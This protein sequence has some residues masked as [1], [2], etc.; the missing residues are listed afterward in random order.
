MK[1]IQ[2]IK[3]VTLLTILL[4]VGGISAKAQ[5]LDDYSSLPPFVGNAVTP[6]ILLLVDN[7]G[8]M[9][10]C[11]YPNSSANDCRS[12]SG[13]NLSDEYSAATD[14]IG[15]FDYNQCYNYASS[16]FSSVGAKPC[17][18]AWDGNFLNWVT[19]RRIDIVKWVMTGG[20]C[21]SVRSSP[22]S[23]STLRGQSSF[24]SAACCKRIYKKFNLSGLAPSSY[25][26]TRCIRVENGNFYV[27]SNSSC[28]S[29]GGTSHFIRVEVGTSTTGVIQD[30]G[31][32][33]RF[34][35]M[36]FDDDVSV[37]NG[38]EIKSDI[39]ANVVSMVNGIEGMKATSWT[40][41]AES[42]YEA[43]RYFAQIPPA[44]ESNDFKV[45]V[46]ND[47]Y[48][49][50]DLTP[51]ATE[52]G[53][54]NS[55]QGRWVPCC[56]SFVIIFTD[57]ESTKDFNSDPPKTGEA[58]LA[59][60]AH[61]IHGTHCQGSGC[62]PHRDDYPYEGSHMLDDV[63]FFGHTVDIRQTTIPVLNEPG[64]DLPGKQVI[65]YYTFFAFGS[66]S[67][68]LKDAAK[69]GGF[70]DLN[71][72]GLPGPDTKEWDKDGDGLPDTYF[73]SKNAFDLKAKLVAAITDILQKSASG[74][75]VSVLATS[76]GG[77]GAIYQAYF[78]PSVF[79]GANEVSWLGYL[80]SLFF[81]K[82]GQ[83]REDTNSDGRLVLDQDKIVETFFDTALLET[84]VRRYDVD[85][86][87]EK[88]G[89]PEVISLSE[90]KP[91]WEGG[92]AL[93]QRDFSTNPRT[94]KTWV[95]TNNDTV[96]DPGEFIDFSSSNETTLRPYLRAADATEGGNIISFIQGNPVTGY[97]DRNVTVEGISKTWRL[98]DIVYSSPVSVGSPQE[99]FDLKYQDSSY[100]TFFNKYKDRRHVIYVGAND[101][102]LHAFNGGFFNPGDD[103]VTGSAVE[104]GWFTTGS[105]ALGEELWGF[106]PQELLPHLKWLTQTAYDN[107]KHVYYVDGSPRIADA[108][109][110]TPETECTSD[111]SDSA[112]IHPGGWGTIL[113]GNL[114]MGGG[115]IN[116][117]LNGNGNTTDP[118]EDR[119]R[120]AYFAL[121]ITDPEAGPKLLWVFKESDLGFTTSNPAIMRFDK[122][123]WFTVFGSGPVT[124]DGE[125][126]NGLST[127]KFESTVSEYGQ[128]YVVNLKTG[129]LVK[130]IT[131][132]SSDRYAFMGN[133]VVYDLP[134]D[135]SSDV[136]YI[137][138]NYYS[139]G[140]WRGKVYRLI[141][142]T[143]DPTWASTAW[144][145]SVLVDA[146]KPALVKPTATTDGY[147]RLWIYF[148][149]GR[150]FSAG[151]VSD[152]T[153]TSAQAMYGIKESS[154]NGCWDRYVSNWKSSCP[155]VVAS[156]LLDVTD[157]TVTD[158]GSLTCGS[159]GAST[160]AG[161]VKDVVNDSTSEKAGW[162]LNL[163]GGERVL[164]ESTILGGIVAGTTYTPG[165]DICIP[166]GTNAVYALYFES[167]TAFSSSV[168]G[169][170]GTTVNRKLD[171][172]RG[173]ASK[174]NI[175]VSDNTT[176]GF[177]QS[178]TG[179]IIKVE[180]I[181]LASRVKSGSR[182]FREKSE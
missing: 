25:T 132:D 94:I 170:S 130:K 48:C 69:T 146:Q 121:D 106:I 172:G 79:E 44:Y 58:E 11:A 61:A 2:L 47:P 53:C 35:F 28:S 139:G 75:S 149:T 125:R 46:N 93:A 37:E 84:R 101:G 159:C 110:F 32:K 118:G 76:S 153:D 78:Y 40:P 165:S 171:L 6:N 22:N 63:T 105:K 160:L 108:Q 113:I 67:Q 23:C 66:G 180:G 182:V 107:S 138:K 140:T 173:V 99:R 56:K 114:R 74:T 39:G 65:T 10:N 1:T 55:S 95:D 143:K 179:E 142:Y 177:V 70:D 128:I 49:F 17:S 97:R 72:D 18:N 26:N 89:T 129:A 167:G 166:Q 68:L 43:T 122:D 64:K 134:R 109:I 50:T 158:G 162:I 174:I 41:L 152:V 19:M 144:G 175:I 123:N 98:G 85:S 176:T 161:L 86:N 91:I 154:P 116:V 38:A 54:K 133:P 45:N 148:G 164:H 51:P 145:L 137:G 52:T 36:T 29:S 147:G 42:A 34:G 169:L 126:D 5:T 96:V 100:N 135:Y 4:G 3:A 117:D 141:V 62:L 92:K 80:Q 127:N 30:V 163:T 31:G 136:V 83:L 150:L 115:V 112:C 178:S 155:T 8:S 77:E 168:I 156:D 111:V 88:T 124:Y 71:G 90:M 73:E 9:N 181:N 16:K 33:A 24:S 151:T 131:T 119:F 13:S 20:Q 81:D 59:D 57:G 104:H 82:D 15:Y 21:N 27:G 87:G 12:G 7:S 103:P 120:S 14:Y 157:V 60:Y 102:M